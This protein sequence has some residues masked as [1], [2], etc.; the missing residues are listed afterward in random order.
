[1][2]HAAYCSEI[3]DEPEFQNV[4]EIMRNRWL[5]IF[6]QNLWTDK[7]LY[8]IEDQKI[9]GLSEKLTI[10][11]LEKKLSGGTK[12]KGTNVRI[13]KEGKIRFAPND[14]DTYLLGEQTADQLKINDILIAQYLKEGAEKLGEIAAQFK[15]NSFVYGLDISEGQN[16]ELRVS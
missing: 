11:N 6:N 16:P 9:K 3:K 4:R 8:V 15:N 10:S 7:G 12:I 13:S 2:L 5:W 14:S 1:M